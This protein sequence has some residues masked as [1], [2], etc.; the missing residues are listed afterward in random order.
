[1]PSLDVIHISNAENAPQLLRWHFHWP[2]AFAL[3]GRRLGEGCRKG[4]MESYVPFD[5]LHGLVNVPIKYRHRTELP[6]IRQGLRTIVGTPSPLRIYRP[7]RNVS[8]NHDRGA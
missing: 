2:R 5:F 8:K 7:E 1:M 4:S 6:Q 3:A